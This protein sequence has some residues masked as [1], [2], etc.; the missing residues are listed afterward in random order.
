METLNV[1]I[2]GAEYRIKTDQASDHLRRVAEL[3]DRKMREIHTAYPDL[4]TAKVA[5]LACLNL[6]DE[7]LASEAAK[8]KSVISK[9][10]ELLEK[11]ES[12]S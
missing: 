5:V 12:I 2:F 11:L 8:E 6:A 3:V 7:F 4:A 9:V 10:D 1:K